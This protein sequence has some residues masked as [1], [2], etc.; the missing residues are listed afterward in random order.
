MSDRRILVFDRNDWVEVDADEPGSPVE[1]D[2][3]R[4]A[5]GDDFVLNQDRLRCALETLL[6]REGLD[7]A[8]GIRLAEVIALRGRRRRGRGFRSELYR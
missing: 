1:P 5:I 3:L 6:T 4:L 2:E 7:L 8:C